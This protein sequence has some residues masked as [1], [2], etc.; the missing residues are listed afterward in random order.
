MPVIDL[1][2][3]ATPIDGLAVITVK[4]VGDE[5]GTVREI[6]RESAFLEA[7][8]PSLGRWVQVNLTETKRGAVRGMHGE[9]MHKL[10]GIAAGEA[11][12]AWVDA[13]PESPTFG[14]VV[15]VVLTVGTQVLVPKGVCNGFQAVADG[16][17]Q[18]L[19]CFDHEWAPGLPGYSFT[20]LDPELG[21][22]WPLPIDPDDASQISVKDR[23]APPFAALRSAAS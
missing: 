19:Y 1:S 5:R 15:T 21:I 12:G 10:V 17:T 22:A 20:P 2:V 13:R 4:Q 18:Y 14:S 23:D 3:Q 16:L 7:G 8:L 11:F 6:Y 9:E